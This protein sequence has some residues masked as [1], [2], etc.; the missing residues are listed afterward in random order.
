MMYKN[1][2]TDMRKDIRYSLY[3][4]YLL[5]SNIND[6]II[7]DAEYDNLEREYILKIGYD[8]L[9]L[10]SKSNN[11]YN[12]MFSK[13]IDENKRIGANLNYTTYKNKNESNSNKGNL[14]L[15]NFF[16]HSKLEDVSDLFISLYGGRF[17]SN[18][19][20]S[21]SEK[22]TMIGTN[23]KYT[24]FLKY[25]DFFDINASYFVKADFS[26]TT[27]KINKMKKDNDSIQGDFGLDLKKNLIL[28]ETDRKID[29]G[30]KLSYSNEFMPKRKY[31]S[32]NS[33]DPYE[34]SINGKIYIDLKVNEIVD[35]NANYEIKKCI[36]T[37]K[38]NNVVS[39]GFKIKI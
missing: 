23:F 39:V 14:Y 25:L 30:V 12:I 22:G 13:L 26:R 15:G 33:K 16:Y 1:M 38:T 21:L 17:K 27:Y 6:N 4:K 5:L 28:T 35:V 9:A 32:F 7:K 20:K 19:K 8:L 37:S 10:D 31:K 18:G 36:R 2:R 11:G 29:V 3:H 34:G 24:H